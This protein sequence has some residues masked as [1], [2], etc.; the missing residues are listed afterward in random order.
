[1]SGA[2]R[3]CSVCDDPRRPA[4]EAELASSARKSYP[5]LADVFRPISS[6]A[7]RRHHLT[8]M[9]AAQPRPAG[10]GESA[11]GG[12]SGHFDADVLALPSG[13]LARLT[14]EIQVITLA[15]LQEV[16]ETGNFRDVANVLRVSIQNLEQL[17]KA[18][19][20]RP[21]EFDPLRDATI[22]A[23]R[24]RFAAVEFCPGCREKALLA[25]KPAHEEAIPA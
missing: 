9:A 24:D 11:P 4:I 6:Q 23:L 3:H 5:Q 14:R 20:A 18:H 16:A 7:L 1:M 22:C 2:G 21:P 13:D 12:T 25:L 15:L 10:D 8:H 19:A 17:H